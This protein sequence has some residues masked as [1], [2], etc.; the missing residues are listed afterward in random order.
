SKI[1]QN[2]GNNFFPTR[3]RLPSIVVKAHVKNSF[4]DPSAIVI[5]LLILP[6]KFGSDLLDAVLDRRRGLLQP[7]LSRGRQPRPTKPNDWIRP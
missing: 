3:H 7:R 5:A 2:D 6:L 1:S 4:T